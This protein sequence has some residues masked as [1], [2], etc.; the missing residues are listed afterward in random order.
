MYEIINSINQEKKRYHFVKCSFN[1]LSEFFQEVSFMLFR[2]FCGRNKVPL[3]W[4][5]DLAKV[6]PLLSLPY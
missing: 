4:P 6:K 5:N 3:L 1:K 2:Y